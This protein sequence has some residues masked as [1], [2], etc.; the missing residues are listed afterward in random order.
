[1]KRGTVQVRD[2]KRK[3][4]VTVKTGHRYLARAAAKSK[5]R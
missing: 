3:K 2:F 5:R 1:V 4:T